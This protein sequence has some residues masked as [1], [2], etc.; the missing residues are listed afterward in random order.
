MNDSYFLQDRLTFRRIIVKNNAK[1][2]RL[3]EA[4]IETLPFLTSLEVGLV[5]CL[6]SLR[7]CCCCCLHMFCVCLYEECYEW[8]WF[9]WQVSERMKVVDVLSSKGFSTGE[10]IIAQVWFFAVHLTIELHPRNLV[11]P[12]TTFSL[13]IMNIIHILFLS[14]FM[15]W[16]SLVSVLE[17]AMCVQTYGL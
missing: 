3:Y 2:R 16:Q 13:N 4:F 5:V 12:S 1:K 8:H 17:W 14:F 11:T 7:F 6:C 15:L 9:L 10:R